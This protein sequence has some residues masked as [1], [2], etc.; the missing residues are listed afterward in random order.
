MMPASAAPASVGRTI[1]AD[2]CCVALQK[3]DP[4]ARLAER[5]MT[6]LECVSVRGRFVPAETENAGRR[7]LYE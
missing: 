6:A 2:G 4:C 1:G 7:I 5:T 3:R